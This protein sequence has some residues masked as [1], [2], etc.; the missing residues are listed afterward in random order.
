MMTFKESLDRTLKERKLSLKAICEKAG[1]SYEQ[2]KKV[3]QRPTASTNVDDAIKIAHALGFTIDEF[4]QDDLSSDR[5]EI[6]KLYSD[7]SDAEIALIRDLAK[8]RGE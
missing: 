8:S 1:V 4:L 5:I 6:A 3:M 7:L 2:M